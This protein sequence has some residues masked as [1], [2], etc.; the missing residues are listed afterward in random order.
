[1]LSR[2]R[3]PLSARILLVDD[4]E[5]DRQLLVDLLRRQ[6]YR[7]YIGTDG[8]DAV[9]KARYVLPDLI[10]MDIRMPGCDGIAACRLL[11]ADPT[12]AAIPLIFLTAAALPE[13]RVLGLSEGAVDYITKPYHFDE[14]R[15]RVAIHLAPQSPDAR[16]A[17]GSTSDGQMTDPQS[18]NGQS[19]SSVEHSV[20]RAAQRLLLADL[21]ETP[22]LSELARAVGTNTRNLNEAFRKFTGV[23]A[24]NYLREVRMKEAGRLLRETGLDIQ[25]IATD[26]GYGNAANFSTA[27]RERFG[28]PPRQFRNARPEG[29]GSRDKAGKDAGDDVPSEAKP[30]GGPGHPSGAA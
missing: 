7:L 24:L 13:E 3:P 26:L 5:E 21:A 9:E 10:L 17:K 22:E 30:A 8:H 15:L 14:V 28:M 11:K 23:T 29:A 20:Y 27:F 4:R 2:P 16:P 19:A 12:T 6:G 1:M 25:T 18:G